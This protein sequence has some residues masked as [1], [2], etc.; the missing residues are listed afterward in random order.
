MQIKSDYKTDRMSDGTLLI[1]A[2]ADTFHDILSDLY[3]QGYTHLSTMIGAQYGDSLVIDYPVS[4]PIQ[5]EGATT[6]VRLEMGLEAPEVKTVTDLFPSSIVYEQE[7]AEMLGIKFEEF[8]SHL[9]LP[10]SF[11]KDLYPLRKEVTTADIMKTLD[12]LG[13]GK[14]EP[15]TIKEAPEDEYCMSIG[16]QHPTHKEPIR[17]QFFVEGETVRDVDLRIGFNHRGLE[18]ALE[19]ETWVQ[20]LYLIERICG[21][22][23]ASH[24]LAYVQSAEKIQGIVDE[25]PDRASWLRV[26]VAE[27]ERI[28]SHVLW[29]GV[30][31][32]DGGYDFMFHIT[33]RDREIVMDILEE[34]TGNRVNY[35]IETIGGVRRDITSEQ[36]TNVIKKLKELRGLVMKHYDILD[37]E[38]SFVQRIMNIGALNYEQSIK[39]A[40]VG[41]TARASGVNFDLRRDLPYAAYKEL[42]FDVITRTEGDVH[43]SLMVRLDETIESIDLCV[44]VL[45]NLPGG[46]IALPFKNRLKEGAA[47]TRV[48]APRGE[49]IHFINSVGGKSPDRHKVRAPTLANI[50]SLLKRFKGVNVADIPMIIRLIDPCVGCMERVTFTDLKTTKSVEMSGKRL[51]RRINSQLKTD[52]PVRIFKV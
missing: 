47:H 22:C 37:K 16:P 52:L 17:F 25:V 12:E 21:I 15:E 5:N 30:L 31:A 32:H 23:S 33:W 11:P 38:Q 43:A 50:T 48:E 8:R 27:L 3:G 39:M 28:H 44:Y 42:P 7:V 6:F 18:K 46:E 19:E 26:L 35:S 41:P 29:Y 14:E 4:K 49:D 20:N 24:Q 1:R 9:L 2:T 36:A 51:I 40:S 45:E 34:I 13:V 10:D